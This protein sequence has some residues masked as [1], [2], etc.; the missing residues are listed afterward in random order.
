MV[1]KTHEEFISQ[2]KL[3]NEN[4]EILTTYE[5]DN[6]KVLCKCKK[7]GFEWW[8]SPS[9]LLQHKGCKQCHFDNMRKDRLKSHE[10]FVAEIY[11]KNKDIEILSKYNGAKNKI[12]CK[13]LIH[14]EKFF[15]NASH[16]LKGQTSCKQ[17]VQNKS[18]LTNLKSH[19]QFVQELIIINPDIELIGEYDGVKTPICVKC[20]KCGHS[21]SPVPNSLLH[22]Y[23]CPQCRISKG[24]KQV[25]KYL[26]QN[27][28]KYEHIKKFPDLRNIKPLSYDF[29]LPSYNLLIEYQGQFHDGSTSIAPREKY[30]DRQQKNDRIKKDYAQKNDYNLLEIWYYDFDNIEVILDEYLYNLKNPVTTTA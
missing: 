2:M 21:W 22:G 29:Y 23:G 27:N 18:H 19:D 12:E 14:N 8:S 11:E 4:I 24:E 28:I 3:I 26:I 5:K 17:C 13:C 9:N 15:I 25:E 1:K 6:I 16:L 30:L 7:C 10:Q 20:L